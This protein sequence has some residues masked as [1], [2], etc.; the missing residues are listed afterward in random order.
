MKLYAEFQII[1]K[2]GSTKIAISHR[3][4]IKQEDSKVPILFVFS[5]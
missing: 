4:S 5:M 1:L 3:C 2:V